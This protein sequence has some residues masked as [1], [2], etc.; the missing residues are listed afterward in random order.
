MSIL[1]CE[2]YEPTLL[3]V[4]TS[5]Q[6]M[7]GAYCSTEW[8]ERTRHKKNLHYFGTGETFVFTLVPEVEKFDWVGK[9]LGDKTPNHC[10]MFMAGDTTCV[11]VGGGSGVAIQLDEDMNNGRS[12]KC[13]TFG[14]PPLVD[15][16][17]FVCGVVEVFGFSVEDSD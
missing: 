14:S 9:K 8:I 10:N 7:F 5:K 17:D 3:I 11:C 4:K 16:Q 13:D 2:D 15:S 1:Q 12:D 6:D